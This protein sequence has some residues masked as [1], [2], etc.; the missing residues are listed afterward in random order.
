MADHSVQ[1]T[2]S[3]RKNNLLINTPEQHVARLAFLVFRRLILEKHKC[4][5]SHGST[6]SP[7][8]LG[9][10]ECGC[11]FIKVASTFNKMSQN[12]AN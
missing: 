10:Y 8:L 11:D 2:W 7:E 4:T 5:Q 6:C 12:V 9:R 3:L 1:E